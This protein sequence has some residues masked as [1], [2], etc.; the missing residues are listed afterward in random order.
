M[1]NDR[2]AHAILARRAIEI[3]KTVASRGSHSRNHAVTRFACFLLFT[4]KSAFLVSAAAL[5]VA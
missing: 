2:R 4:V 1:A 5:S 3:V